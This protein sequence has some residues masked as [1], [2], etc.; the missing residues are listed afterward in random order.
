MEFI[1]LRMIRKSGDRDRYIRKGPFILD[2]Q[3]HHVQLHRKEV[4]V[5]PDTFDYLATLLKH[6]PNPVSYQDLVSEAMGQKLGALEAQ[7]MARFMV[8]R[9]RHMIEYDPNH[10]HWLQTVTGV[11]YRL[12]V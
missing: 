11:G 1:S 10:P 6:S 7:D 5:P 3:E 8:W 12:A 2:L 9:L 4:K